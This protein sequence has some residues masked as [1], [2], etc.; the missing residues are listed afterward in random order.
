MRLRHVAV[1]AGGIAVIVAI[2]SVGY[3]TTRAAQGQSVSPPDAIYYNA[4]IVTVD[5]RVSYAQAVA[6]TGD[7][8]T[9]VGSNADVR[10]LAG[11]NTRQVDLQGL[12]VIPGIGDNHLHGVGG[13]PGIDLSRA[14]SVDDILQAVA[15]RV[16]Q[17][18][19]GDVI[20]S[21][22]N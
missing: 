16:K 8:F 6:M 22:S 7:T 15:A 18:K 19:P 14:R 12:T 1:I 17:S 13:G 5:A 11:P 4:K 21:N 20:V 2:A 10:R 3:Y 9:A